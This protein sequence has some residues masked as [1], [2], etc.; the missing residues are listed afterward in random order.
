VT[1]L[2]E[3]DQ[4]TLREHLALSLKQSGVNV[5]QEELLATA[6]KFKLDHLLDLP[7]IALS[8]GQ[9]RRARIVRA[10]LLK[11]EL[12]VLEEP[13]S[14]LLYVLLLGAHVYIAG[15]D[16]K[17]RSLI[18]SSLHEYHKTLAPQLIFT[19]RAQDRIPDYISHV[20]QTREDASG[21][22]SVSY[23]GP[24]SGWKPP[25]VAK[26]HHNI[27]KPKLENPKPLIELKDVDVF[28]RYQ[29][30]HQVNWTVKEGERWHLKG[31]NGMSS[32]SLPFVLN[33][34]WQAVANRPSFQ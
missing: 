23:I 9:T 3:E 26:P 6:A 8:N 15:L 5:S 22:R 1:G 2:L 4:Q 10:L 28:G 20:V 13:L 30:L 29:I 34:W 33:L 7:L 21:Q 27:S 19:L 18:E 11:P 25:A 17:S 12:L 16:D 31:H 14:R 32:P 24:R